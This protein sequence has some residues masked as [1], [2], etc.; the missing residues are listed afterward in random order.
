L[1]FLKDKSL[2]PTHGTASTLNVI[3]AKVIFLSSK[4]FSIL[5]KNTPNELGLSTS[6][7]ESFSMSCVSKTK[8]S[9][10][11]KNRE[12]ESLKSTQSR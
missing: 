11:E 1:F 4:L 12:E 5:S 7:N 10:L 6:Q 8:A 9:G 2:S 3:Q